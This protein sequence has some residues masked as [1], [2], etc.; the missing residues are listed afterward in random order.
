MS[1]VDLTPAKLAELRQKAEAAEGVAPSPWTFSHTSGEYRFFYEVRDSGDYQVVYDMSVE[2]GEHIAAADPATVLAMI[3][4]IE[5]LQI[6]L[7]R[8]FE[9]LAIEVRKESEVGQGHDSS[10]AS[11]PARRNRASA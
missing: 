11:T 9:Q 2:E 10:Y 3:E 5:F 7:R 1:K 6:A 4:E 8:A